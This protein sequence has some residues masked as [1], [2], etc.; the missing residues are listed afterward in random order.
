MQI[1]SNSQTAKMQ[2][3]RTAKIVRSVYD[4][5][6]EMTLGQLSRITGL[7]VSQLKMI[8]LESESA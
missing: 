7:T 4:S 5:N 2:R 3:S 6:P 8:L 1:K